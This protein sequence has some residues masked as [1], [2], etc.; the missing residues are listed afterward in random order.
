MGPN[1]FIFAEAGTKRVVAAVRKIE[2]MPIDLRQQPRR[3]GRGGGQRVGFWAKITGNTAADSPAQNRWKYAWSEV[4]KTSAGYGGWEV[5]SGGRS[6]TTSTDPACNSIEDMN[7]AANGHTEGNGVDPANLDTSEYTFTMKPCTSDNVVW[8]RE[9][10]IGGA[11][12]Y[13][14]SYSN[15]VDGSCD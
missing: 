12:E 4:T 14:F 5:L 8:M 11:D 9:V 2:K 3:G 13:W 1:G 7:T 6:G 15:G 10:N